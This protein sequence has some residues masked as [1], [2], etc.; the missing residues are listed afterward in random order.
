MSYLD[1]LVLYSNFMGF[2]K[3]QVSAK[4]PKVLPFDFTKKRLFTMKTCHK[5]VFHSCE[6]HILTRL[7]ITVLYTIF[8]ML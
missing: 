5:Y 1:I 7:V 6:T 3:Y 4:T 8:L 2:K